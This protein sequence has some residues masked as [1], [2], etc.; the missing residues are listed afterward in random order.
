MI[1]ITHVPD[2]NHDGAADLADIELLLKS[3]DNVLTL[4]DGDGDFRSEESIGF[5]K[6]A[7]IVVTNPP[8]SLFREYVAQLMAYDKKFLILGNMNAIT[9]KEIFPLIKANRIWTGYGFNISLIYKTPYPNLLEANRKYVRSKGKNPDDGFVKVPAIC[10]FTN[11][12]TEKRNEDLILYKVF[13]EKEYPHYGNYD[14]INVDKVS[15][16]PVNYYEPMG[17]PITFLNSYNPNQFEILALG[18]SR[19]NFT[20][21][22]DY[23]NPLKHLKNG[24]IV[25]GG[26]INCVLAIENNTK[27]K[28]Q[29]YYSAENAPFIIAPYARILIKRRRHEN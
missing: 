15:D 23:I 10:W 22:K 27:P 16:I 1:E 6:E 18:N 2:L 8:F 7:D 17:V 4:L 29:I 12:E 24:E 28:G 19:D 21:S 5:L 11:L 13:S 20:P 25:G 9:Y 26:A 14:A 3:Q